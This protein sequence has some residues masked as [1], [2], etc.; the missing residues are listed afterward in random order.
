MW[1]PLRPG[2]SWRGEGIAQTIENILLH[3][4]RGAKF[5][6]VVSAEHAVELRKIFKDY[7]NIRIKSIGFDRDNNNGY[8][9]VSLEKTSKATLI[10]FVWNKLPKPNFGRFENIFYIL[11]LYSYYFLQRNGLF[12][13]GCDLF[14][15]PTPVIP[16]THLLKGRKI[17]SFWDPFV[18]EYRDFSGISLV[19]LKKFIRHFKDANKVITQSEANKNY[20]VDVLG[21]DDGKIKVINNGSPSYE[22]FFEE[23]EKI[24]R[25]NSNGL[26]RL[27][28]PNVFH[29][30]NI[31][32]AEQKLF[33][34]AINKSILWRLFYKNSKKKSR[35]IMISTQLRPYK[36]FGVLLELMNNLV[37][38]ENDERFNFVLTSEIPKEQKDKYP[39]LYE[40][41]HEITRVPASQHAM[42]YYIADL[43]LHPSYA[44]GGLGVYPQF[45]AASVGTPSLVNIGRHVL[46]QEKFCKNIDSTSADFSE[47]EATAAKVRLLMNS[48]IERE[49]NLEETKSISVRWVDASAEYVELLR[50]V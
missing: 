28:S 41:L 45:E 21:I 6:L 36:G 17:C 30:R 2:S 44:E 32:D 46:E 12:L 24:G 26:L 22:K 14:W 10:D 34:D 5:C 35:V 3:A 7:E 42:L 15:F 27:W 47:I 49:K 40:R 1:V 13:R 4:S 29:G 9:S 19:L 48:Q 37:S 23:L 38:H 16:G 8:K 50:K 39:L 20:L 33:K 25:H 11:S 31:K 18:F 43:V